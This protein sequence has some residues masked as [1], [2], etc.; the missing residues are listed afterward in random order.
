MK[1]NDAHLDSG[2]EH[3]A[4]AH[5]ECKAV[6]TPGPTPGPWWVRKRERDGEILDCFVA[7]P[8]VN[9]YAY[10]AEILGDDEYHDGIERKLADCNLIAAAPEM[11]QL[12]RVASNI[13]FLLQK[14]VSALGHTAENTQPQI[15]AL[16]AK[17]TGT[18]VAMNPNTNGVEA[19]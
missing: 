15:A 4:G 1:T 17:A 16:I 7:A 6:P 10:D 12:L 2:T 19:K 11:L 3:G 18:D 5:G 13:L 9:G 14:E 8:D